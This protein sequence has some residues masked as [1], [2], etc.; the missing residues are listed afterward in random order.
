[1]PEGQEDDRFDGEEFEDWFIWPKQIAGCE[2]EEEEGVEGQTDWDVV[3]DGNVEVSS[4]HAVQ[5]NRVMVRPFTW[6]HPYCTYWL[7]LHLS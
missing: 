6:V 2:E 1:M 3:D 7:I 5:E 4:I